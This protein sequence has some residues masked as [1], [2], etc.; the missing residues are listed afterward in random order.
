MNR[1]CLLI[2]PSI[3]LVALAVF[4]GVHRY[5]FVNLDDPVYIVGN[6]NI[7][8]GFTIEAVRWAFTSGE[9]ANWHPGTWL[10]HMLDF[11]LFGMDPGAHHA[12]NLLIHI[13]NALL[14]F[15]I[16]KK[17][18]GA[19]W[20]SAFVA[21]VF[22]VHPMRAE[23]V[24]WVS[25]RKDVLSALFWMLT[26]AAYIRYCR[27]PA[28]TGYVAVL[29]LFGF[30][31]MCK[32]MLTTLPFVLLLM[33]YWPLDRLKT[34]VRETAAKPRPAVGG[35]PRQA[36]SRLIVE[37]IPLFVL[38]AL[39]AV[40]TYIVQQ[41]GGAM[42]VDARFSLAAR[43]ANSFTSYVLYIYKTVWPSRLAPF[44]PHPG[45]NFS[46]FWTL[47]AAAALT[48][49]SILAIR[50]GKRFRHFPVGWFWFLGTLAPVIGWVQ[51]GEQAYADRYTYL[52]SIG[53]LI[54][55][56]WTAPRLLSKWRF[57]KTALAAASAAV[58]A[59]LSIAAYHQQTRWRNSIVLFEHAIEVT[60]DNY[61]A[62]YC[63]AEPLRA[64]GRLREAID[65]C[66]ECLRIRPGH[67]EALNSMGLAMMDSGRI[68]EA[69]ECFEKAVRL[70]PD[71]YPSYANL[72]IALTKKG[73][74]DEAVGLFRKILL[75][76]DSPVLRSGLAD[77]L[78]SKGEKDEAAVH[79][80][81]ALDMA[82]EDWEARCKLGAI[83]AGQ[84][85]YDEAVR[86]YRE[87]L[88]SSPDSAEIHR[89]LGFVFGKQGRFDSAAEEYAKIL[90][91]QPGDY[92][93]HTYLGAALLKLGRADE[94]IL[95]L[96]RA[97]GINPDFSEAR[98]ILQSIK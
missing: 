4:W 94:A 61:H 55:F 41:K 9:A 76:T 7:Q 40:V 59:A 20:Q 11:R 32:P 97:L 70:K 44:Y 87:A 71:L 23:S 86:Q 19:V 24:A 98:M 63:I 33:D 79:L 96:N 56:A 5:E 95:H 64:A 15:A 67:C 39:S 73:R 47:C 28:V 50:F 66:A 48:A 37:K 36:L 51:V 31:L 27:R 1:R 42:D 78:W 34:A 35:H 84:G 6:P 92:V 12:V 65:H 43:V 91:M 58:V 77:A 93:A 90:E 80:Q 74:S 72:G 14:L 46:L 82:P 38:A 17:T 60:K 16:L 81:K 2:Y 30:G 89:S 49:V 57:G 3:A 13:L 8:R 88:H 62:H 52:P 68:D 69:I 18:T 45:E 85:R 75:K 29:L 25:E 83:Y 54:I 53:L 10:S 21:L 22:A 26:T